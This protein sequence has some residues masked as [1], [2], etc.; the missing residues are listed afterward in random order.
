MRKKG[1]LSQCGTRQCHFLRTRI[2]RTACE[3]GLSLIFFCPEP[4]H[5]PFGTEHKHIIDCCMNTLGIT[6]VKWV[7]RTIVP[8]VQRPHLRNV[9]LVKEMTSG[10]GEVCDKLGNLFA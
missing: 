5:V 6:T 1:N 9:V 3:V 10:Q 7:A 4:V 8:G 2:L